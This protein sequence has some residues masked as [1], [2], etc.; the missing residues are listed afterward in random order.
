MLRN[1]AAIAGAHA[2]SNV[3]GQPAAAGETVQASIENFAFVPSQLTVKAGT[4]VVWT[5]KDDTAHTVTSNDNVFSSPVLD[6]DQKFQFVF[7]K[8]GKFP[9]HCKLHPMMTGVVVVQ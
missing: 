7:S 8:P 3:S 1:A 6:T 9:F 5:N 4:T 2:G